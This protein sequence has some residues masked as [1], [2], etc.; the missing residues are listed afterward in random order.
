MNEFQAAC[1]EAANYREHNDC[2]VKAATIISGKPYWHIHSLF[3]DRGRKHRHRTP[4]KISR[5]VIEDDLK[6]ETVEIFPRKPCG[7]RF[8]PIT[9]GK[10]YP[11]GKYFVFTRGHMFALVDGK[12]IDW[13]KGR[14]HRVI[15]VWKVIDA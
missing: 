11:Q 8:T 1:K 12:V 13:T 6:M 15:K 7:G 14:R 4:Q 9:I 5:E 3:A 10:Y 2:S